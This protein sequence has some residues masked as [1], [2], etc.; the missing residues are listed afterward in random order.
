LGEGWSKKKPRRE[1]NGLLVR[2]WTGGLNK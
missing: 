2:S 1:W